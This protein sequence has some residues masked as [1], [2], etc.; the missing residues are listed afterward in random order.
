MRTKTDELTPTQIYVLRLL[1][2]GFGKAAIARSLEIHEQTVH[3]AISR[4]HQMS[5][6][7][8]VAEILVWAESN[9]HIVLPNS[10]LM[11][12]PVLLKTLRLLADGHNVPKIADLLGVKV[13]TVQR[14]IIMLYDISRIR[15]RNHVNLVRW[16]IACG[17][18][19]REQ[20][21]Q[22]VCDAVAV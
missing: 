13:N 3:A 16:G 21:T 20:F 4:L 22:G 2:S 9:G 7:E 12:R 14:S 1:S 18:V 5:G 15:S 11:N 6:C 10:N 17:Y 19:N 8:T